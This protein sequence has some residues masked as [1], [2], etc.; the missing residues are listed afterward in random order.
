MRRS[1][2]QCWSRRR[3]HRMCET[4]IC[5]KDGGLES[6]E[7]KEGLVDL[8]HHLRRSWVW[9]GSPTPVERSVDPGSEHGVSGGEGGANGLGDLIDASLKSLPL[10]G[11]IGLKELSSITRHGVGSIETEK[12]IRDGAVVGN[13]HCAEYLSSSALLATKSA[14]TYKRHLRVF[15][16]RVC[17]C[18]RDHEL[19]T[20]RSG[21][22]VDCD[23]I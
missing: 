18:E 2:S 6:F 20:R 5:L 8:G 3:L 7:S 15:D 19:E 23:V 13:V 9:G 22:A 4:R 14:T 11:C 12:W 21:V 10:G 16:Q 1:S 17:R